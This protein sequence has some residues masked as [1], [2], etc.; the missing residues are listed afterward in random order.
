[1]DLVALVIPAIVISL[2]HGLIPSHWAPFVILGRER[3]WSRSR[4]VFATFLGGLA[5]LSSTIMV[6]VA[7]GGLGYALSQRYEEAMHW[8]APAILIAVGGWVIWRGHRCHHEHG[9]GEHAAADG[10]HD[11][12]EK[13]ATAESKKCTC[14]H[15]RLSG[16]DIAAL[17]AL[18]VMMFFSPCLEL[19]A[20][21]PQ[22][23][24]RGR[25]LGIAA[26][27]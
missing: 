27:S 15:E 13:D 20:Y 18:C 4:T 8:V 19:E 25:W 10:G 14:G 26:V 17:G 24:V 7:V 12:D 2:L 16:Q 11:H 9:G 3:G 23:A 21:Y 1:M 5:H 6:G 22:V